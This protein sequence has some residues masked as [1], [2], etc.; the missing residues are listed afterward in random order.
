MASSIESGI[1]EQ[2]LQRQQRLKKT[3]ATCGWDDEMKR[4]VGEV[5]AALDRMEEGTFGLC[6]ACEEPIETKRLEA[7][8][9]AKYC[10]DCQELAD[11]G[12]LRDEEEE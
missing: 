9:G 4:L 6:R 7:V 10:L 12:L 11:R 8:P 3:A 2:L 1:R 5:D